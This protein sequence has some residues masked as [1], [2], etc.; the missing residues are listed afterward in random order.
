MR[1]YWLDR[2]T[3]L[4]PGV[5]AT[6]V[7]AV[8]LAEEAFDAHFPGNPVFPGIYVLEGL[9]QTG[10]VL[11]GHGSEG[12]KLALMVSIERARFSSFARPGDQITLSVEIE[13]LEADVARVRGTATV[14]DR[15]IAAARLTFKLVDSATLIPSA[16]EPL[17][18]Q[19][20]E[21]WLGR[22]LEPG[23]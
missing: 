22:Y 5:R 11:L 9:A 19:A 2:I 4:E 17:W 12:R 16:F 20:M 21:T 3:D 1:H 13:S 8:G 14:G 23:P 7:K 15:Q 6:G 18:R 10:G